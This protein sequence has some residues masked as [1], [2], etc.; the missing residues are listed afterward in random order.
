MVT[1]GPYTPFE[2]EKFIL[3]DRLAMDRT[4]LANERTLMAYLRTS[5]TLVIVAITFLEFLDTT[6]TTLLGWVMIPI[7]VLIAFVGIGRYRQRQQMI[8]KFKA[9]S[10]STQTPEEAGSAKE[11][12]PSVDE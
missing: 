11:D 2:K 3:R 8:I 12:K 7:A 4:T 6:L 10:P 9:I 5:L 1:Y